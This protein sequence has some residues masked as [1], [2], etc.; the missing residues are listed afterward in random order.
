M[1]GR[2]DQAEVLVCGRRQ[3]GGIPEPDDDDYDEST[4]ERGDLE[5]AAPN[6]PCDGDGPAPH[7]SRTA[8]RPPSLLSGGIAIRSYGSRIES[9]SLVLAHAEAGSN[10]FDAGSETRAR[11]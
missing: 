5:A 7:A 11:D 2:F 3:K 8:G 1:R 6:P 4:N 10:W 9:L